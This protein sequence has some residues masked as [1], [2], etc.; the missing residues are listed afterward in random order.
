MQNPRGTVS[1]I[2]GAGHV[3]LGLA[4]AMTDA[5]YLVYG[6]DLNKSANAK[7]MSGQMPFIEQHGEEFLSRALSNGLLNMTDSAE[8]LAQSETVVVVLGTPID[9]NLNP[10]LRP[11]F[12]VVEQCVIPQLQDQQLV[13]LRSTVSPGTTLRVKEL[14]ECKTGKKCGTDFYLA[15][16]PERVLQTKAIEEIQKLPQLVGAFDQQS[17]SRAAAFFHSFIRG[18]CIFLTPTEAELT[19]LITNMARYVEFALANE[20]YLIADSFGANIHRII[21]AANKDYPRMRVPRPGP[22]VGGPCLYKDGFFLVERIPFPELISTAFKI[23]EGMTMH[24]VKQLRTLPAKVTRVGVLGL[25]F[26]ADCDDTRNSLTFKL[27]KQLRAQGYEA[28]T[29][30]PFVPGHEDP[31]VLKGCDAVILMTPHSAFSDLNAIT[32]AVSNPECWFADLWGFWRDMRLAAQS[33]WFQVGE[34][35]GNAAARAGAGCS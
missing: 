30:D 5:S 22:N 27:L 19:K 12:N 7:I 8:P 2:G 23:N 17:E 9:D 33:G 28:V 35:A 20:F 3:G 16:T 25:T 4:L 6:I 15:Y 31:T 10:N 13:L 1:I 34:A 18:E 32:A 24:L 29:V 11:L 14:I 26:K 21:E